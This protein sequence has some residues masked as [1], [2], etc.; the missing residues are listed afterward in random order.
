MHSKKDEYDK[1]HI[2]PAVLCERQQGEKRNCPV[3]RLLASQGGEV[4]GSESGAGVLEAGSCIQFAV[5]RIG[6]NITHHFSFGERFDE[7]MMKCYFVCYQHIM[8]PNHQFIEFSPPQQVRRGSNSGEYH[9]PQAGRTD[10][11]P[12]DRQ[13]KADVAGEKKKATNVCRHRRRLLETK[14]HSSLVRFLHAP[15]TLMLKTPQ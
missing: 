15:L 3:A 13:G 12:A 7:T 8:L 14:S 5:R 9:H 10:F 4:A 11:R 1:K 2:S 6:R